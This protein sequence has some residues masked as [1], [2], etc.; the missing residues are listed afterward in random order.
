L[1]QGL[2]IY[3][4]HIHG[5]RAPSGGI[6]GNVVNSGRGKTVLRLLRR[7]RSQGEAKFLTGGNGI[8]HA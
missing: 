4:N 5:R 1:R 7:T 6:V 8:Q 2:F 3:R